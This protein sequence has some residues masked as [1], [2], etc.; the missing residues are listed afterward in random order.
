MKINVT[1]SSRYGCSEM[2]YGAALKVLIESGEV[3]RED[4]IVQVG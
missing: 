1:F 3:K 2:Q 4:I